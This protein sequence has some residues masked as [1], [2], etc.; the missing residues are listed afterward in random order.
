MT[1]DVP[2]LLL[3]SVYPDRSGQPL[4]SEGTFLTNDESPL[5]RR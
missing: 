5:S 1:R 3:R 2:G 4:L